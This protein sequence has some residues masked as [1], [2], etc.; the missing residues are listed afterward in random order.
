MVERPSSVPFPQGS[1]PDI[2]TVAR[3]NS[4]SLFLQT[5][6]SNICQSQQDAIEE[7]KV[8]AKILVY[9]VSKAIR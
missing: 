1:W 8:Q 5:T 6:L 9:M 2:H 4:R 3:P 7:R